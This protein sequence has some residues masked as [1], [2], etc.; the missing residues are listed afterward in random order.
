METGK[1][2]GRLAAKPNA[3]LSVM[4]KAQLLMLKKSGIPGSDGE[5]SSHHEK[6]K[7]LIDHYVSILGTAAVTADDLK[8]DLLG[9]PR[10]D[11]QFLD[12][13]FSMAELKM[14]VDDIPAEKAPG[15]DGFIGGFYKRCWHIIASDMLAAL[16][17]LYS[18]RE[19]HWHLL[20]TANIVL[21]PKKD[22]AAR[23]TD[24]RPVSLM[25]SVAKLLCK[26]L[27]SRL[28]PDLHRL[29][30]HCQS[31]FIRGRS[32]QDNFLYVKNVIKAAHAKKHPLLF[33]KLDIAKAFDSIN[34]GYLLKVLSSM[35][36]GQRWRNVIALL[37]SSS[38]SRI[39]L[40]GTPG[41]LFAHRR[42][43]RQGDPLSPMLFILA[44][45]PL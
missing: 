22:N 1:R 24:Y 25:H 19:D 7:I 41:D 9:L 39:M 34:W 16:N 27:A 2:S 11:L 14:A 33:L 32:I 30:S 44:M 28:A 13:P 4:E 20:N 18:L 6:A 40:N 29:V 26:V 12:E 15:P 36:F 43:L 21:L 23:V 5:V 3:G 17:H 8:W 42:G 38:K 37:L 31:A 45:E 35:G 10:V